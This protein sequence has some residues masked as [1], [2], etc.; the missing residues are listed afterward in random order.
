MAGP[1]ALPVLPIV[2]R[3]LERI[4]SG[5]ATTPPTRRA[6]VE[7]CVLTTA[8]LAMTIYFGP[9][10]QQHPDAERLPDRARGRYC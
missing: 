4:A 6:L 5:I 9:W 10:V 2:T 1:S 8:L 3:F 7:W